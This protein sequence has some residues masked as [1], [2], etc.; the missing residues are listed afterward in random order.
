MTGRGLGKAILCEPVVRVS[1]RL[2]NEDPPLEET[3]RGSREKRGYPNAWSGFKKWEGA[4]MGGIF[5]V[6]IQNGKVTTQ[7]DHN[8]KATSRGGFQKVFQAL[9]G[10]CAQNYEMRHSATPQYSTGSKNACIK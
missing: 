5:G 4:S 6:T 3:G 9:A 7:R 10:I 1:L 8:H 2:S